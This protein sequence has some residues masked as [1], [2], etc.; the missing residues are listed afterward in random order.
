VQKTRQHL[1]ERF[2][3]LIVT[4]ELK[5]DLVLKQLG[6]LFA[7]RKHRAMQGIGLGA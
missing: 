3:P 2:E 6:G 1:R 7:H 5:T 4:V